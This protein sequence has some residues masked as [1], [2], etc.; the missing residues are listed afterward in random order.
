MIGLIAGPLT[1]P[2]AISLVLLI[3]APARP[4]GAQ[5]D[6]LMDGPDF[7]GPAYQAAGV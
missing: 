2:L 6:E 3:L 1:K 4:A 5:D 7:L